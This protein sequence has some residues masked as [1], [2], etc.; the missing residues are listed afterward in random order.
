MS[1]ETTPGSNAPSDSGNARDSDDSVRPRLQDRIASLDPWDDYSPSQKLRWHASAWRR[2]TVRGIA[3]TAIWTAAA[4]WSFFI[5][6][7]F[8]EALAAGDVWPMVLMVAPWPFVYSRG[9][10]HS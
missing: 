4:A 8:N 1:H 9:R 6:R 3:T 7:Q 2:L 10:R 5:V